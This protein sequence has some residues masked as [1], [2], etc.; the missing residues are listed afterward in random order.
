FT[1]ADPRFEPERVP[2]QVELGARPQPVDEVREGVKA[3]DAEYLVQLREGVEVLRTRRAGRER[4]ASRELVDAEARP[5]LVEKKAHLRLGPDSDD[6]HAKR[7]APV[8]A[9]DSVELCFEIGTDKVVERDRVDGARV[10]RVVGPL[11]H[12]QHEACAY[13]ALY[14]VRAE[15]QQ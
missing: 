6:A 7:F 8:L 12:F 13:R 10:G 3:A 15:A 14:A 5:Q 9:P 2:G 4:R 1:A 11:V